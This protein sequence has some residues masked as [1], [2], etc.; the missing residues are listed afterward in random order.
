MVEIVVNDLLKEPFDFYRAELI[1][2]VNPMAA[3]ITVT[4]LDR[5]DEY[6]LLIDG[7]DKA[8]VFLLASVTVELLPG[9]YTL[10]F[11]SKVETELPSTCKSIRVTLKDGAALSLQVR[12]QNL[13]IRILDAQEC[14]LNATHGFL[15]GRVAEGAHVENPIE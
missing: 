3:K 10:S 7:K 15:C 14:E 13:L 11:R 12:T 1:I 9:R 6:V 4:N 2:A 8:E 5:Y